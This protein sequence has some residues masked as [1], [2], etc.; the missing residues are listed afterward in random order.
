MCEDLT[1]L[2][3]KESHGVEN[4]WARE[5]EDPASIFLSGV[6]TASGPAQLHADSYMPELGDSS[7]IRPL[8]T[9]PST[10]NHSWS[11]DSQNLI[12]YGDAKVA[13][14]PERLPPYI[15]SPQTT[16]DDCQRYNNPTDSQGLRILPVQYNQESFMA[17]PEDLEIPEA[18]QP[19]WAH[20]AVFHEAGETQVLPLAPTAPDAKASVQYSGP[21][22]KSASIF[23]SSFADARMPDPRKQKQNTWPTERHSS[24]DIPRQSFNSQQP[25]I[26]Q[27]DGVSAPTEQNSAAAT[28]RLQNTR[29]EPPV[30][31]QTSFEAGAQDSIMVSTLDKRAQTTTHRPEDEHQ[32]VKRRGPRGMAAQR[33]M[34]NHRH[35]EECDRCGQRFGGEL[36]NRRQHLKRHVASKHG[37]V[38]FRCGHP[39]CSRSYNRMDNLHDHERK[40][41]Q[42]LAMLPAEVVAEL[43]AGGDADVRVG[44]AGQR[45][46]IAPALS[47]AVAEVEGSAPDNTGHQ[48]PSGAVD[49]HFGVFGYPMPTVE[50]RGWHPA[51]DDDALDLSASRRNA[52]LN[53]E[54][55][56]L[57]A[58][59]SGG[60]HEGDEAGFPHV[61]HEADTPDED[62]LSN[63]L[64]LA[65]RPLDIPCAPWRLLEG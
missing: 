22:E 57:M 2:S 16:V 4:V 53:D 28:A 36:K 34:H 42:G 44:G 1:T 43:A 61:G 13:Q 9:P 54:W 30:T 7:A 49:T 17:S 37:D 12:A 45:R 38:R 39:G 14:V 63:G 40:C 59:V 46:I 31:R 27:V 47:A 26:L 65:P 60:Q 51:V 11:E 6:T 10:R 8:P 19:P 48:T 3:R 20:H 21:S 25:R 33:A 58:G 56:A 41:H 29:T 35:F 52:C 50:G 32:T 24:N 18:D 15:V 5:M 64:G 55:D 62:V 23:S